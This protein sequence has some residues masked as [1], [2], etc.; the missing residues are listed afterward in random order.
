MWIAL[1]PSIQPTTSAT[2]YSG[3]IEQRHV[4]QDRA[5][6][7]A[8]YDPS[9]PLDRK[10]AEHFAQMPT[11]LLYN[12]FRLH[13]ARSRHAAALPSLATQRASDVLTLERAGPSGGAAGVARSVVRILSQPEDLPVSV[14]LQTVKTSVQSELALRGGSPFAQLVHANRGGAG[15]RGNNRRAL[16]R[17]RR[18]CPGRGAGVAARR[19]CAYAAAASR[20]GVSPR[21]AAR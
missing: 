14:E 15:G 1:L 2:A 4:R 7:A 8:A 3:G 13:S 12:V 16:S 20:A 21:P 19:D 11:E 6:D 18:G 10:P 5:S 9:V 17:E